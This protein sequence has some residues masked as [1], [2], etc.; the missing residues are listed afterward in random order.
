M[1]FGDMPNDVEMLTCAASLWSR[2]ASAI[3][4]A[5]AACEANRSPTTTTEWRS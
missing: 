5:S 2:W 3:V 1:A 4:S